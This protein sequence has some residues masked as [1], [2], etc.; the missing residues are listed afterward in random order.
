MS[1]RVWLEKLLEVDELSY[2]DLLK[3][4]TEGTFSP[5]SLIFNTFLAQLS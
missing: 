1:K 4:E 3:R 5:R 2:S